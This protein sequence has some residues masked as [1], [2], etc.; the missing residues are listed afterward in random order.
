MHETKVL[1]I[2]VGA[3]GIKGGIIDIH[4][5]ELLTERL[6]LP[7]PKPAT[8][9][10]VAKTFVQLVKKIGYVKGPI[11][12]GFPAIIKKGEAHSAA[13]IHKD[14]VGLDVEKLLSKATGMKVSVLNDADAAG[15]AEMQ[16]GVGKNE[17]G[18]VLLITIGS[19]LGTALFRDGHLLP[20][21]EFGHLIL[22]G[23]IAERFAA[24]SIRKK[25]ELSWKE[26]GK[27]F[28]EYLV[29]LDRLMAP[30]L[31][32]LGGGVSKRFDK[33]EKYLTANMRIE[34]AELRNNAGAVGAASYAYQMNF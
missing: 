23:N 20:N 30:D 32:I 11:G 25:L 2:D 26:W 8:P 18:T 10:K 19:G 7:T 27:R 5:G 16:F 9:A 4:T 6:R 21:S 14:W 31:V 1:G 28:N 13:N 3:S 29:H 34:P 12:C 24:D 15:I 22:H 33:F 17:T